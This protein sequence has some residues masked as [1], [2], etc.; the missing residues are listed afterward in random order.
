[1]N[2]LDFVEDKEKPKTDILTD[3]N[4]TYD[5]WKI[6]TNIDEM[7][8]FKHPI[9]GNVRDNKF[10][11][12]AWEKHVKSLQSKVET[13]EF[14]KE[15]LKDKTL[16]MKQCQDCKK[17]YPAIQ[18]YNG[19]KVSFW[20]TNKKMKDGLRSFCGKWGTTHEYESYGKLVL[21]LGCDAER[22]RRRKITPENP[23]GI[24]R[25][26]QGDYSE[27]MKSRKLILTGLVSAK[28]TADA[29]KGLV[30]NLPDD[31]AIVIADK[32]NDCCARSGRPFDYTHMTK[33]E[34]KNIFK[35]SI[36]RIDNNKPHTIDN[37]ELVLM[38]FNVGFNDAP[39]HLVDKL[40]SEFGLKKAA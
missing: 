15:I 34:G 32:Q 8:K 39:K 16:A 6:L 11:R 18:E 21:S 31:W 17:S 27:R 29:R 33:E 10:L 25:G 38:F 20:V 4:L 23:T 13:E 3:S 40:C 22:D 24:K 36:N 7:G 37:C 5:D 1:M 30:C 35:P 12:N 9:T 2:L 26:D 14:I 19:K 28:K